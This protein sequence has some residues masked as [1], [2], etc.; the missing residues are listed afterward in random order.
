MNN[1]NSKK[2]DTNERRVHPTAVVDP[3]A[4]IDSGVEIGAYSVIGPNVIIGRGCMIG[5]HVVIDG[6][7]TIGENNRFFTGA[8]VGSESQDLK[9]GGGK[10]R[11]IIGDNNTIRE[12]TTINTSTSEENATTIGNNNLL[13]AYSHVAHECVVRDGIVMANNATLA[14]HVT[15]EDKVILG[16]LAAVHQFSRIGTMAIVG[17][18]SKVIKDIMPF[19]MVDGHPA[20]WHGV[21]SIGMKRNGI[22]EEVRA[23]I[24]KAFRIICRSKLNVQQAL[25]KLRSDFDGC[26][27]TDHLIEFIENSDRGVCR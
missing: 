6:Y 17:G 19:S 21:N 16:G 23:K 27:E 1:K 18:C 15:V 22:E 8:V 2:I 13:M 20:K 3:K 26:A 12:Y 14:G 24:K 9:Y 5:A 11:L 10:T 7:T 4:E 25:E